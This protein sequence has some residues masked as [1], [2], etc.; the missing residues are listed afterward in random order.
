[1]SSNNGFRTAVLLGA[2]TALML[3]VGQMFGGS[4][5]LVIALALSVVMN[6]GSLWFSDKLVLR[7]YGARPVSEDEA[8]SLYR[9][10]RELTQLA[11][12]PMPAVY[13][14]QNDSPNA[15]ATGRSP[16]HAAIAVTTGLVR[17]LDETEL[18]GVLAHELAHVKN[19]DTL[20]GAV[21][22]TLAG[23][24]TSVAFVARWGMILG[25]GGRDDRD[26]EGGGV[27]GLIAMM[28]LAPLA[29]GLIQTAISR[30]REFEADATAARTTGDPFGLASALEKLTYAVERVPM[31]AQPQTAHLFI[32][33]PLTGG[34]MARLFST[35]PPAEERIRRLRARE[36]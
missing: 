2:L 10:V 3:W 28:I 32:V 12:L 9:A 14:I 4:Q 34:S 19:R 15:F 7:M 6:L 25:G 21:A 5:G 20:T 22:A 13:V 1:M 27:F 33:N 30:S 16:S 24:I 36:Y 31:G 26:E 23:V 29:A 17:L 11:R 35:H 8:P 18:R